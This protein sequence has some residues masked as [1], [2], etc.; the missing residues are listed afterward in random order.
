VEFQPSFISIDTCTSDVFLTDALGMFLPV[1]SASPPAASA[2]Q[3]AISPPSA[4]PEPTDA[5]T[6]HFA[7]TLQAQHARVREFLQV[8]RDRWQQI[9]AQF[10][11][12]IETLQAEVHALQATNEGLQAELLARPAEGNPTELAEDTSRR[13]LMAIDDLRDLKTRNA[14]LQRQLHEAQSQPARKGA[15]AISD[16]GTDWEAQKRRF[17]AELESGDQHDTESTERRL[18]IQEVVAR[19]DEIIA[20][21]NREIEELQH[22]LNNQSNSLGSLAVGAAALEQV[23]DQDA[24][25]REERLRLQQLQD[26]CRAKLRQAEI[27]LAM[28]RA[29]LARRDA[30]IEEK[31]RNNDLRHASADAEALAPTGRPVRGRWR[32]QLGLTDDGPPESERSRDRR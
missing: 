17:L 32:T 18:K 13:Y 2:Q 10:T 27:E 21:K 12:Q 26:E 3:A 30:E 19:T 24:I 11:H 7:L 14:E 16:S 4:P 22:L 8:Q 5:W 31:I 15:V 25:I 20:E 23:L 29:R 28:E 6:A 1:G 9:A